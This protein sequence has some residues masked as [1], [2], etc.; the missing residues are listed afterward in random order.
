VRALLYVVAE[1]FELRNVLAEPPQQSDYVA[2]WSESQLSPNDS[3]SLLRRIYQR[4][5]PLAKEIQEWASRHSPPVVQDTQDFL[6]FLRLAR[7]HRDDFRGIILREI[8]FQ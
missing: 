5:P 1:R 6:R 3:V 4:S 2:A 8:E 7:A